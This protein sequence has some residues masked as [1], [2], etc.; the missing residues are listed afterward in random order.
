M[1]RL[2]SHLVD[3]CVYVD[4]E[5]SFLGVIS[6]KVQAIYINGKKVRLYLNISSD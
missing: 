3:K 4:E 6:A 5:I 2:E 1:W